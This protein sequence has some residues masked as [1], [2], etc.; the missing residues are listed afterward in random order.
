MLVQGFNTAL[1]EPEEVADLHGDEDE[2]ERAQAV[3]AFQPSIQALSVVQDTLGMSEERRN[4]MVDM[5]RFRASF[6]QA[7]VISRTQRQ[8]SCLSNMNGW[9][10]S[11]GLLQRTFPTTRPLRSGLAEAVFTSGRVAS[12]TVWK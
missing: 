11:N 6:E 1:T 7:G 12:N 2:R 5:R 8:K 4:V 10:G 9:Y 3:E